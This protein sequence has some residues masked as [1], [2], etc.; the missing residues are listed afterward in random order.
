MSTTQ[1][2][3]EEVASEIRKLKILRS[4]VPR[5]D[6]FGTDNRKLIEHQLWVLENDVTEYDQVEEYVDENGGDQDSAAIA[7]EWKLG[8]SEDCPSDDWKAIQIKKSTRK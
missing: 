3:P 8:L 1:P 2:T 7:L 4:R 6:S 5:R